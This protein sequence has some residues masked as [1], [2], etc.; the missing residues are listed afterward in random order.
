MKKEK[1]SRRGFIK[2]AAIAAIAL[3]P[4]LA[5]GRGKPIMPASGEAKANREPLGRGYSNPLLTGG[6]MLWDGVVIADRHRS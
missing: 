1:I 2:G 3:M 5:M 6:D 4:P